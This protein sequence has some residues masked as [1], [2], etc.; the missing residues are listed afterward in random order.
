MLRVPCSV[1]LM[2]DRDILAVNHSNRTVTLIEQSPIYFLLK[3]E[4]NYL[5]R[6]QKHS[7]LD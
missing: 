6:L 3:T 1:K 5:I 7:E 4:Y 2:Q